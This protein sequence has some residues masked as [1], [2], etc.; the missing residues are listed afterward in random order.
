MIVSSVFKT[1]F[2]TKFEQIIPHKKQDTNLTVNIKNAS[3]N[4]LKPPV[5][6]KDTVEISVAGREYIKSQIAMNAKEFS[7]TQKS[8]TKSDN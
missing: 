2:D 3:S 1:L 4:E 8:D 7:E 5:C 6:K